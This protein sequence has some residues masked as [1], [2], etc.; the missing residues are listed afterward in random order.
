VSFVAPAADEETRTF[1]VEIAVENEENILPAGLTTQV[2]IEVRSKQ[3]Y[4]I[5]PSNLTLNDAGAV[6][7]KTVGS[8]NRVQFTPV[9]IVEDA[10][11]F[12]WVTGLN[13]GD[14]VVTVGQDFIVPGQEVEPVMKE[15]AAQ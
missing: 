6:G 8:D 14:K 7:V 9:T 2:D 4:K 1:R 13:E 11:E 15:A 10:P 3:A 5:K 12:L